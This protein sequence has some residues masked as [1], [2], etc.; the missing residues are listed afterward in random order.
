M[1][2]GYIKTIFDRTL[3][4]GLLAG[5]ALISLA[6]SPP[7]AL[8]VLSATSQPVRNTAIETMQHWGALG[9]QTSARLAVLV[10]Y[11]EYEKT[12]LRET[13]EQD[14]V[15]VFAD[16]LEH[17]R[18]LAQGTVYD[19]FA[20]AAKSAELS[21][22][23]LNQLARIFE[24]QI[25][26]GRDLR[27]GDQFE[28]YYE[29]RYRDGEKLSDGRILAA[30]INTR[31]RRLQAL[32]HTNADGSSAYYSPEGHR[33]SRTLLRTPV[34]YSHITSGF[35]HNRLHPILRY[36]RAHKGIDLAAPEDTPVLAAG[37]GVISFMDDEEGYGELIIIEHE[38][39][40]QTRYGHL[41]DYADD[42]EVGS[43]VR[44][45]QLIGYVGETGIT[46]GPHLHFEIRINGVA[47]N[48]LT[49]SLPPGEAIAREQ[50]P[51]FE[52]S[53]ALLLAEVDRLRSHSAPIS[54]L[55]LA[56]N[57]NLPSSSEKTLREDSVDIPLARKISVAGLEA[58]TRL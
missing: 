1:L 26:L 18:R 42:L 47:H 19:S 11:G 15:Y 30:E 20:S 6:P 8:A 33:I 13:A 25:D 29:Q 51:D 40:Y 28:V 57:S 36:R 31:N 9:L 44:Q 23:V 7:N 5:A 27:P 52:R 43:P 50:R 56:A 45:G 4:A 14:T 53:A 24:G 21:K 3:P 2:S 55:R 34:S 38:N 46:S 54:G 49:V 10:A 32:L 35:S 37:D 12:G 39:G 22:P 48:P 41:E 17:R 16:P 58:A